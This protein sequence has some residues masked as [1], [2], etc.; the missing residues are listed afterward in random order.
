MTQTIEQPKQ[1]ATPVRFTINRGAF[2]TMLAAA[3][4]IIKDRS[5]KP[6]LLCVKIIAGDRVTLIASDLEICLQHST[7]IATV[8]SRGEICIPADKLREI[9]AKAEGD[10]VEIETVNDRAIVR[11]GDSVF[12][13]YTQD[14]A[15][16]P[17][18]VGSNAEFDCW[19]NGS[20][21]LGLINRASFA[22]SDKERRF[23]YMGTFISLD[24]QTLT[25]AATDCSRLA[26]ASAVVVPKDGAAFKAI[27]PAKT[28]GLFKDLIDD[29]E[30]RL[31]VSV[32]E[33]SITVGADDWT[34]SSN[35]I[36]GEFPPY[37]DII[38]KDS[39]RKI[40]ASASA[41]CG[42]LSRASLMA[43]EETNAIRMDMHPMGGLVMSATAAGKGDSEV[44]F[45][46]KF[47]G[48]PLTYGI[49]PK[50][51]IE[52]IKA[53]GADQVTLEFSGDNRPVLVKCPDPNWEYV[54]MSV[55]LAVSAAAKKEKDGVGKAV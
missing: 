53:C 31:G 47:E 11:C 45:A 32:T 26:V 27:I 29:P 49:N 35:L 3:C 15:E 21:L 36:E 23:A 55:N 50:F 14:P 34:L 20:D 1:V 25:T 7:A 37:Q 42:A 19:L 17:P 28:T 9:V 5:P 41:L 46:C 10:T 40:S 24:G 12:K 4:G 54:V 33:T 6:V 44:K 2:Q 52:G 16:Y 18:V 51:L 43:T 30:G 39:D 13:L 22:A 38:P 48:E 8:E